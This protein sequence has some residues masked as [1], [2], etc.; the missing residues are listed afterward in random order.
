MTY[1]I[2]F[3][4]HRLLKVVDVLVLLSI[5][6][7]FA[8]P[9]WISALF[10][11]IERR[12][13][14]LARHRL[15]AIAFA[16]CFPLLVRLLMLPWYP[17]PPPQ[18]HDEFS[19][20]L[21]ADTFA[22][23][24][25][26]NPTPPF[27]EHFETEYTLFQPGY[28]SQYQPAQGMVLALGQ[29]IFGHPWWGVWLSTGLLCGTLCW[30]L[31]FV[32]PP[33]W[34]LAGACGAALQ[35]GIFG[36]WM[37][38][39][40][41]GAVAAT[42]GALVFGS[43]ARMRK[44]GPSAS[45]GFVCGVGVILLFATRPFEGLIWMA[46]AAVW[47]GTGILRRLRVSSSGNVEA[48][49]ELVGVAS[50]SLQSGQSK[51]RP[52]SRRFSTP[53]T[54]G[55]VQEPR[56]SLVC[57]RTVLAF[58][59]VFAAGAAALAWYNWRITGNPLDPPYLAYR[60]IYGTPQP[61]WWQPPV[62][63]DHF[64]HPELRGNYLN[65]L[66]LYENRY[67]LRAMLDSERSRLANFWRF[68]VGPFFTPALLFL[69]LL[70][71]DRKIRPWLFVSALFILDKAGYHAWYPA[72]NAPATVLIVVVLVQCWRHMRVWR[73]NR[74]LGP[75][76]SRILIAALCLTIVLGNM[77]RALEVFA[78]GPRIAHLAPVWESLYPAKRLRDDVN[79]ELE[80][81]PGRHLV[82][83]KYAKSHCFCDE[84]VFNSADIATQRIIYARLYTPE[85]DQA[86]AASLGDHDVWLVEP[87][88][89][90]YRLYRVSPALLK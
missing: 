76:L 73:R 68:F 10:T 20:L 34:A 78:P 81:I 80:R 41:G 69:Y 9:A 49:G 65:Q 28:A 77:G 13:A 47:A 43:L 25:V 27:W 74:G 17:P 85:T 54:G 12:L 60:R 52:D 58:L 63:V 37:N 24:R 89:T 62:R 59:I 11:P 36:I 33:A 48:T 53:T 82:F 55:P 61:Y 38:S 40:F 66:H 1:S 67:S 39:Y 50:G 7:A 87:D 64:R 32:F 35:F 86:L 16:A 75:A 22:H 45:S 56:S 70:R 31:Q 51:N 3:S 6:L 26:V 8:R 79:S 46:V 83:V 30:A 2:L 42:A 14:V 72:Q 4:S 15:S 29:V 19:Y 71:R 5:A 57:R 84:W 44:R 90:P 88:P 21:Q 18:I 23:G